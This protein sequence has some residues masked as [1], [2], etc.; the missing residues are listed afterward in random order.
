M[1]LKTICDQD[2]ILQYLEGNERAFEE[3]LFRH[4]NK[5]FTTIYLFVKDEHQAED[6]FQ[7]V[8][9]KIIDTLRKGKYNMKVNSFNG[10]SV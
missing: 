2:L 1:Q 8:F 10:L 9:I 5:I 3:L 7:E 6:I 4:K